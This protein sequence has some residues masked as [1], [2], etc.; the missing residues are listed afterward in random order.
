MVE[1]IDMLVLIKDDELLEE[2]ER[3]I[4]EIVW[5]DEDFLNVNIGEGRSVFL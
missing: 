2:Y 3:R 5:R 4:W 1:D